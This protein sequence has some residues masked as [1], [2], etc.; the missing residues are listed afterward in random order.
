MQSLFNVYKS[1]TIYKIISDGAFLQ[2]NLAAKS[3]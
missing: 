2:K 1:W 3:R